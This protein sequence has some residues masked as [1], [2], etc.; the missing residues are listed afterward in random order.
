MVGQTYGRLTVLARAGTTYDRKATWHC[1]CACGN[2]KVATGKEMRNG[3]T[4]SCGC[5]LTEAIVK[6][7]AKHGDAGT[8]LHNIWKDMHKRCRRHPHYAGRVSVDPVWNEYLV[9]KAWA[10][11]NGYDDSLTIDRKDTL[12]DYSPANCRWAT[13]K[14]QG[15]NR[16]DRAGGYTPAT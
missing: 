3:H 2:A 11:A 15:E 4:L 12:G 8:R 1:R 14:Q 6:R 7:N 13:R 10:L 9:F 16:Y 5:L